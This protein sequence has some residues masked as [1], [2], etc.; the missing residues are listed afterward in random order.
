[1][2]E[3]INNIKKSHETKGKE[4]PI[5]SAGWKQNLASSGD[6]FIQKWYEYEDFSKTADQNLIKV[7]EWLI[8]AN[9]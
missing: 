8:P 5:C 6:W 1:M 3:I 9:L 2:I 4:S 7:S